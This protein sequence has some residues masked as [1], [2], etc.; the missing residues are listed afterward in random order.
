MIP[1]T[2]Y[3]VKILLDSV[4]PVGVRLTTFECEYPRFIH[5]EIMTHR[6][7]SKNAA[8]SRAIPIQKNIDKVRDNPVIPFEYGKNQRGMQAR[9]KLSQLDTQAAID[10]IV[11]IS[12]MV[13]AGAERLAE[14]G[15]H[16][17]VVNRY[18]EPF[19]PITTIISGT[20]WA[21]FFALRAHP[22]AQPE[23]RALAYKM[24][25]L[26]KQS[27]PQRLKEGDW[28]LPLLFEEDQDLPL[29]VKKQISVGR[30]ARVSHLTHDGKRD[31]SQDIRLH[32]DLSSANP[33]HWSPFEHIAQ[34][35]NDKEYRGNFKGFKQYRKFFQNENVV[36]CDYF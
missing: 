17:Q 1:K 27:T 16:K 34:A 4:N 21:N 19:L 25:S 31:I 3:T 29:E 30:V 36:D 23:F 18:L 35:C 5:S 2:D 15:L 33:G 10:T 32:N 28:H 11:S 9:E 12:R 20:D 8:S 7:L 13:V 26:Y 24:L 14:L 22:D 6:M